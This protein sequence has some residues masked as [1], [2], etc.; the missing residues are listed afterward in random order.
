MPSGWP[1]HSLAL[2]P[3][4]CQKVGLCWHQTQDSRRTHLTLDP[5]PFPRL[6]NLLGNLVLKMAE[7]PRV[8]LGILLG[9]LGQQSFRGR[10]ARRRRHL[11]WG[12]V[13]S[14]GQA[15]RHPER[16]V[17]I[18]K[19]RVTAVPSPSVFPLFPTNDEVRA[20]REPS[21]RRDCSHHWA[22]EAPARTSS[23]VEA[24]PGAGVSESRALSTAS[25]LRGAKAGAL[26]AAGNLAQHSGRWQGRAR[27]PAA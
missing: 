19:L 4:L 11:G 15:A 12:A 6:S 20:P 23:P 3:T 1:T 16:A 14:S 5:R 17:G 26:T 10:D 18:R 22:E 27:R 24:G 2:A 25:L 21:G 8:R 13:G 9:I 7:D